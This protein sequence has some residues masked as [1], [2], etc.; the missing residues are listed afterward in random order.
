MT[1]DTWLSLRLT[2][3]ATLMRIISSF[4]RVVRR[5]P[6]EFGSFHKSTDKV[7]DK[8]SLKRAS[9][10]TRS[11]RRFTKLLISI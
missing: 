3:L 10:L 1:I 4:S 2:R 9:S 11:T 8:I 5:H 7:S 6:E